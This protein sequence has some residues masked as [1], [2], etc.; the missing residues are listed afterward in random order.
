MCR[1]DRPANFPPPYPALADETVQKASVLMSST[2]LSSAAGSGS[3][4]VR[5]E[6]FVKIDFR[7]VRAAVGVLFCDDDDTP[8]DDADKFCALELKLSNLA[9]KGRA[10]L[11]FLPITYDT[12]TSRL[13]MPV[14]T[15]R[16]VCEESQSVGCNNDWGIKFNVRVD[17]RAGCTRRLLGSRRRVP[18]DRIGK[19]GGSKRD[20]VGRVVGLSASAKAAAATTAAARNLELVRD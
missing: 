11:R 5:P 17:V 16:E 18:G 4:G 1:V 15:N 3:S 6:A 9:S 8:A 2:R 13:S 19:V 12:D 14:E 20:D 10:S 7:R